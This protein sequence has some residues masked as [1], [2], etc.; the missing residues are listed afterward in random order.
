VQ[1]TPPRLSFPALT[2]AAT[3]YLVGHRHGRPSPLLVHFALVHSY[4]TVFWCCAGIFAA[5][6][7]ICGVLLRPGPLTRPQDARYFST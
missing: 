3:S 1:G 7:V 6:A 4:T 5:G 2:R